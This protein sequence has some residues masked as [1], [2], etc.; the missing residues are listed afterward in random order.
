MIECPSCRAT[1][2]AGLELCAKCGAELAGIR[3][4]SK[5]DEL[6]EA[7]AKKVLDDRDRVRRLR[8]IHAVV[9]AMTFFLLQLLLGLPDSLMPLALLLNAIFS[10][11]M[12]LPIGYLISRLR[13][14]AIG[15]ALIS[16]AAFM[17]MGLLI[18]WISG[19][20]PRQALFFGLLGVIPGALIGIHVTMDE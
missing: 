4:G 12:G 5:A 19:E 17:L 3:G 13:A 15:G 20:G 6:H 16:A 11:V 2:A 1:N 7:A 9:G 18:G 8:R 14:G 10:A